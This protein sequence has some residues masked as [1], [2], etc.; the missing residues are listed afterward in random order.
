MEEIDHLRQLIREHVER[1]QM[2]LAELE[3]LRRVL[4]EKK[5]KTCEHSGAELE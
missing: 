5:N 1:E 2:L 4:M 3:Y